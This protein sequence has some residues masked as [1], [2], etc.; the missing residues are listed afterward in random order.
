MADAPKLTPARRQALAVLLEGE[1]SSREVRVSNKTTPLDRLDAQTRP[2]SP[3]FP[4]RP[5]R[6]TVYWSV[7]DWLQ[8]RGYVTVDRR[9]VD[10]RQQLTLTATGRQLAEEAGNG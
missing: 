4:L 3:R 7:A 1:R 10:L 5:G 9:L 2:D 6:L 8:N